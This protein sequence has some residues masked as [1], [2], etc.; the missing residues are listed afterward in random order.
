M[1]KCYW[2]I[3][4]SG[5]L[6]KEYTPKRYLGDSAYTRGTDNIHAATKYK[7]KARADEVCVFIMNSR[8]DELQADVVEF[9]VEI[10]EV[11][12]V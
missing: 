7:T 3:K 8:K 1:I 4:L 2:G 11:S 12:G 5:T 9:S 6:G 10:L